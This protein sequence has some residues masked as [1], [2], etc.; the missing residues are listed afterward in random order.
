MLPR[1][2]M[3]IRESDEIIDWN[4]HKEVDKVDVIDSCIVI[5]G[6]F[7]DYLD[8]AFEW[9]V[10]VQKRIHKGIELAFK[11]LGEVYGYLWW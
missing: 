9:D 1:L 5:M 8:N 2:E 7:L 4:H 10:E 3:F 6:L 11:K